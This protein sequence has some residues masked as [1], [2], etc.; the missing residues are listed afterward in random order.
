MTLPATMTPAGVVTEE[1]VTTIYAKKAPGFLLISEMYDKPTVQG[2]GPHTGRPCTF[3][4]L[5]GCN[6][7]CGLGWMS[8]KATWA[9]DSAYTWDWKGVVGRPYNP[10]EELRRVDYD[11]IITWIKRFN[12]ETKV[13][14]LVVTGGE[15]LLQDRGLAELLSRLW[16]HNWWSRWEVH[17]ETN[18]TVVPVDSHRYVTWFSVSPKLSN[19]GNKLDRRFNGEALAWFSRHQAGFKFV[20]S[21]VDDFDE[22]DQMVEA[23]GMPPSRV[24]IMP[25]G[26]DSEEIARVQQVVFEATV[27]RG[28]NLTS[29][30]HIQLFG[31]TRGT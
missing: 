6:L 4:R 26:V 28:Y 9:C 21:T 14:L 15:P 31:N 25:A 27:E 24:Y 7:E 30:L 16:Q 8:G 29:R 1:E 3:I 2:E 23:S 5:G 10:R 18:G 11:E 19:S 22:I 17:V 13:R 12:D 20:A